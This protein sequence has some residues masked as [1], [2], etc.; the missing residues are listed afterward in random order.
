[1]R[2][3]FRSDHFLCEEGDCSDI[4]FTSVFRSEIDLKGNTLIIISATYIKLHTNKFSNQCH[5]AHRASAHARA[6]GK[7]AA[8]QAR[9]LELEFTL[10]PRSRMDPNAKQNQ[11]KFNNPRNNY[12]DDRF[13]V[14]YKFII[15]IL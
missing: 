10:A 12:R 7:V 6:I 1:M 4:E 9:T 13:V 3:H 11:R 2:E 8:K 15:I 14:L 5:L